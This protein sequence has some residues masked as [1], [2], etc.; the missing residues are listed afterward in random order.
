MKQSCTVVNPD[1]DGFSGYR[2]QND[3]IAILIAIHIATAQL[4]GCA[5]ALESERRLLGSTQRD[6]NFLG[7]PIRIMMARPGGRQIDVLVPIEICQ[8]PAGHGRRI[9]RA[10]QLVHWGSRGG[11]TQPAARQ[12][13]EREP[14]SF[15]EGRHVDLIIARLEI[16][17]VLRQARSMVTPDLVSAHAESPPRVPLLATA[18]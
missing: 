14:P 10:G 8:D 6:A 12:G 13:Q 18:P 17:H 4:D 9:K 16:N 3:Q 1:P 7:V 5:A 11:E 15:F 2:F